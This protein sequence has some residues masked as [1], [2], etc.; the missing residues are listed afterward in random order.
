MFADKS[1]DIIAITTT[2]DTHLPFTKSALESGKHV[3]VE[4]PFVPTSSEAQQLI[5]VSSK[6]GKLICVYQNRRWDTDFL[7]VQQLIK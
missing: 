7:T 5:D 4:K 3:I 6:T 1:I 2:P